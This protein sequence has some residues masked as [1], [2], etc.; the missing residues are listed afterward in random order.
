MAHYMPWY[1]SK[2]F[3]GGWGWHW[4]MNH[5]DPDKT[6]ESQTA[7]KP[8]RV[9]GASRFRP[10]IGLYDS[11]DTDALKC[12]VMLMKL[13]GIDG[14]IIDWY[15]T[16]DFNDYAI[17]NRNTLRLL[18]LL[19]QAGLRF[20]VCY[21]DQTVAQE[22]A[23]KKFPA[24]EAVAHGQQLMKWM[25]A[26]FFSNPSYLRFDG[27]PVLLSF[28]EPYYKDAQ[29]NDL[30]SVLPTKPFYLTEHVIRAQT[31]A[32]GGFDWPVPNGG[33]EG[34]MKEQN[35][36]YERAAAW[37]QFMAAAYPRFQDIYA[38]AGVHPSWGSIE[39]RD[40]RTY[41]E[42]LTRGLKSRASVV[43]LVTWND[44][45]EGTQIEPSVEFGYRDLEVTQKLRRQFLDPHFSGSAADLRLP[46]EWYQRKKL[47]A[48]KQA[49]DMD[50][51]FPLVCSGH[52]SQARALLSKSK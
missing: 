2:G 9:E 29:W 14:V 33:F 35:G 4:T 34:A 40:G 52:M 26:N 36:F 21:E 3:S 7:G 43:Q 41:S 13:S 16:E 1:A 15:G 5:F 23:G 20:V 28:G 48:D 19:R 31:A 27:R 24:E 39:D 51:V 18:P 44:W 50:A 30:F 17:L 38:Q 12:Q 32:T 45:G 25:Q 42:T 6:E 10:L 37:P 46:V 49:D 47:A 11:G 8:A 22:V